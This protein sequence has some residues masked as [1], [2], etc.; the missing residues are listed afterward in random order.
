M[1]LVMENQ[2]FVNCVDAFYTQELSSQ[3]I[4]IKLRFFNLENIISSISAKIYWNDPQIRCL[5]NFDFAKDTG[6]QDFTL[7]L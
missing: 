5:M 4:A 7:N 6:S 2:S 3:L 1:T